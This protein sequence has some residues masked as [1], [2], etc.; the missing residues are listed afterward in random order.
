MLD[1]PL[2]CAPDE[3]VEELAATDVQSPIELHVCVPPLFAATLMAQALPRFLQQHPRLRI[4]LRSRF[5]STRAPGDGEAVLHFLGPQQQPRQP[6]IRIASLREVVCASP[7]FLAVHGEPVAPA[8]LDPALCV[9]MLDAAARPKQWHLRSG[10]QCVNVYP[11]SALSFDDEQAAVAACVRGTGFLLASTLAVEAQ[12]AS[13]LL[14]RVLANWDGP[15]MS[16]W[17]MYG[18]APR[19]AMSQLIRLLQQLLPQQQ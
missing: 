16:L 4:R 17:L 7:E 6:A 1:Q 14:Q 12:I 3:A 9:G 10:A 19:G 2:D 8:D 11:A 5:S 18:V 13:G 15:G